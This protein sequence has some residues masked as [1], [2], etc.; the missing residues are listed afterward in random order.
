MDEEE[1]AEEEQ[2][3]DILIQEEASRSKRPAANCPDPGTRSGG[4]TDSD[5]ACLR[6][7]HAFLAEVSDAFIKH[8]PVG[9]LMKIESTSLKMREFERSKDTDDKLALNKA[10]MS[11]TYTDVPAGRDNRWSALHPGRFLAGAGCLATRMWLMARE[12]LG[13][14]PLP[15]IGSYDMAAVGL[16]G[17]VSSKGWSKIHCITSQ[18]ISVK[19]FN[20]HGCGAKSKKTGQEGEEECHLELAEFKLALRALRTALAFVM[21]W[22]FSV[23]ALEG[24]FHQTSFCQADLA[25]VEKKTWFLARF[26]DYILHQNGE[27]WRDSEPFYTAG[28][29]KTAWAGFFGSQPQSSTSS[30]LKKEQFKKVVGKPNMEARMSLGIC[31]AWNMGMCVKAAGQCTT[32]KGKPLKHICDYNPDSSKP[33]EVCGKDHMQKDFHK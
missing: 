13:T 11:S 17:Y 4:M 33:L 3:A 2:H 1:L 14:A 20:I 28:E 29:L 7:K 22:N 8:T 15:A 5:V 21:P 24:F 18:K 10:E 16:T 27:R 30:K 12:R 23:L 19:M 6:K 31:F 26:T 25:G 32:M 9:D